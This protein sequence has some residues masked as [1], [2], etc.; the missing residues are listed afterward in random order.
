MCGILRMMVFRKIIIQQ[1]IFLKKSLQ[2][3]NSLVL[4]RAILYI[5]C[6][7]TMYCCTLVSIQMLRK[8]INFISIWILLF[9]KR[10]NIGSNNF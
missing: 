6:P 4:Y 10:W 5:L 1:N 7:C 3:Q 2:V 8:E 9:Q